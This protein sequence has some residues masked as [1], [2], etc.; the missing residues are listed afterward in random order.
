M[1]GGIITVGE[2]SVYQACS[3]AE[4]F[5]QTLPGVNAYAR[6]DLFIEEFSGSERGYQ[7]KKL[8]KWRAREKNG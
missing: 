4:L 3:Q 7:G 2:K 6:S 8:S 1:R 5:I